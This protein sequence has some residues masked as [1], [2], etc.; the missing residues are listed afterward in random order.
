MPQKRGENTDLTE[1]KIEMT[2]KHP[3]TSDFARIDY[4]LVIVVCLYLTERQNGS[5]GWCLKLNGRK[6]KLDILFQIPKV[7]AWKI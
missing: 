1:L 7:V 5:S 2:K 3:Q 4:F 6:I